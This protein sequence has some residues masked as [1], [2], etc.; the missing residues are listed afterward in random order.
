[1]KIDLKVKQMLV[2]PWLVTWIM[3]LPLV[4]IDCSTAVLDVER[5]IMTSRLQRDSEQKNNLKKSEVFLFAG[6]YI[7]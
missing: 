3:Q 6:K 5:I 2:T 1:M 4:F 7:S